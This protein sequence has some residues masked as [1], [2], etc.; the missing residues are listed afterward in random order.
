MT[1]HPPR[2]SPR[3]GKGVSVFFPG[4][5]GDIGC[6]LDMLSRAPPPPMPGGYAV[7]EKVFFTGD[8]Y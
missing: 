6:Y 8:S 1:G 7:G 4:N 2:S 5:E 3:F